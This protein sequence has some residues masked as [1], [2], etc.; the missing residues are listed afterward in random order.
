MLRLRPCSGMHIA[1]PG[2][3]ED[4]PT[5]PIRPPAIVRAG[6]CGGFAPIARHDYRG[7]NVSSR[8]GVRAGGRSAAEEGVEPPSPGRASLDAAGMP[9]GVLSTLEN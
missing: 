1:A 7:S 4:G 6:G 8:L 9:S 3:T 2:C 5:A